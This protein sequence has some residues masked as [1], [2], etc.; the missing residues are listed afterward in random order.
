M[1]VGIFEIEPRGVGVLLRDYRASAG[2]S[3]ADLAAQIGIS[4][5][6]LSRLETGSRQE[7]SLNLWER[8]R[9]AIPALQEDIFG[10][11]SDRITEQYERAL[12]ALSS[13]RLDLA[14]DLFSSVMLSPTTDSPAILDIRRR[15]KF[16]VA[17]IRRDRDEVEGPL[18]AAALY[19]EL[20]D[21]LTT[22]RRTVLIRE[23]H[24]MLG[25]CKEMRGQNTTAVALYNQVLSDIGP[26]DRSTYAIRLRTRIGAAQTKS[27]QLSD[28]QS[29]LLLSTQQSVHL[30]DSVPYSYAYEKQAL[31]KSRLNDYEGALQDIHRARAEIDTASPLRWVQSYTAETDVLVRSGQSDAALKQLGRAEQIAQKYAFNHQLRTTQRLRGAIVGNSVHDESEAV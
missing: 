10:E 4:Q 28:A 3:Q 18:G 20:L 8:L 30:D 9:A 13:G 15:S 17:G 23:T 26:E 6:Y 27:G 12:F 1:P 14:E 31:L 19:S 25:A 29:Q 22:L 24:L 16:R 21:E 2:L 11:L 7:L 5:P